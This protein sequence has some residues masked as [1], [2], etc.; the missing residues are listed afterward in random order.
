MHPY[1]LHSNSAYKSGNWLKLP[2]NG[3]V[4]FIKDMHDYIQFTTRHIRWYVH[5][6]LKL[7]HTIV[8]LLVVADSY[9][10]QSGCALFL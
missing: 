6:T 5:L 8:S 7:G 9:T 4:T 1:L 2:P 10:S 3:T